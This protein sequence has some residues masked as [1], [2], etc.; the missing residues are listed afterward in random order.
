MQIKVYQWVVS[1]VSAS[2]LILTLIFLPYLLTAFLIVFSVLALIA[3]VAYFVLKHKFKKIIK[4]LESQTQK[5]TLDPFSGSGQTFQNS[6][7][8]E[9]QGPTIVVDAIELEKD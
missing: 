6:T 4:D 9:T 3:V 2:L 8:S 1:L 7:Y 5:I